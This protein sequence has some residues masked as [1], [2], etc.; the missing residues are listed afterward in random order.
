MYKV[1]IIEDDYELRSLMKEAIEKIEYKVYE[2]TDFKKIKEAFVEIKPD[3]VLLDINLP[4]YDGYYLCHSLR[5]LSNVPIVM[6]S[7]RSEEID[8]VMALEFGADDYITK[9]FT[10]DILLSKVKATIRRV[11]GEYAQQ[12]SSLLSIGD[13]CIDQQKLTMRFKSH[14]IELSKNEFKLIK[15][16][17]ENHGRFLSREELIEEVWDD[18]SFVDDNTLTVNMSRIKQ[19]LLTIGLEEYSIKS[20]RGVGY[21]FQYPNLG[22]QHG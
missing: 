22:D 11:Y 9:P 2:P 13:L 19:K 5:K 20:K 14:S 21:S 1:F 15:K 18:I 17:M 6:I 8:Q 10:L 7:A 3:I 4:Y 12:E 16:M